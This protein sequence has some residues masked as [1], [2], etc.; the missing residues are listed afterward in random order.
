MITVRQLGYLAGS[1]GQRNVRLHGGGSDDASEGA[2]DLPS[3]PNCAYL[4]CKHLAVFGV[5][6]PATGNAWVPLACSQHAPRSWMTRQPCSSRVCEISKCGT[7]VKDSAQWC[8]PHRDMIAEIQATYPKEGMEAILYRLRG[9]DQDA[10]LQRSKAFL[11]SSDYLQLRDRVAHKLSALTPEDMSTVPLTAAHTCVDTC[12]TSPHDAHMLALADARLR[13]MGHRAMDDIRSL[14]G[15]LGALGTGDVLM[16][17]TKGTKA[18]MFPHANDQWL[19]EDFNSFAAHANTAKKSYI[20]SYDIGLL[21]KEICVVDVDSHA[22]AKEL[23]ERFPQLTE[24]PCEVTK[25]GMHYF[26]MRSKFAD[27]H[28]YYDGVAQLIPGVD[29]KT[30]ALTGTGGFLVVAPS[31]DKLWVRPPWTTQVQPIPKEILCAIATPKHPCCKLAIHFVNTVDGQETREVVNYDRDACFHEFAYLRPVLDGHIEESES[32][33]DTE[34]GALSVATA[35]VPDCTSL[36]FQELINLYKN[37][38]TQT[39][40]TVE[41]YRRLLQV[42]DFLGAP[43][44]VLRHMRAGGSL[45]MLMEVETVFPGFGHAMH[46][47]MLFNRC[48]ANDL[49]LEAVQEG[50]LPSPVLLARNEAW[51]FRMATRAPTPAVQSDWL[52]RVPQF[53]H[54]WLMRHPKNLVMAGGAALA[55]L[56]GEIQPKA[57][58]DFFLHSATEEEATTILRELADYP[59]VMLARQNALAVTFSVGAAGRGAKDWDGQDQYTAQVVLRLYESP[60][61]VLSGFDLQPVK[62]LIM[63]KQQEDGSLALAPLALPSWFISVANRVMMVEPDMFGAA[64]T[65]RVLKYC[66]RRYNA[67]IPGS[68]SAAQKPFT[69]SEVRANL[70]GVGVLV[71]YSQEREM[72]VRALR[73][74]AGS[75]MDIPSLLW[76][77][78]RNRMVSVAAY[79]A[80]YPS[81][82]DVMSRFRRAK[83]SDYDTYIAMN[84]WRF[85]RYVWA[86]AFKVIAGMTEVPQMDWDALQWQHITTSVRTFKHQSPAWAS[87][88]DM[89][90]WNQALAEDLL[91]GV[92]HELHRR[93]LLTWGSGSQ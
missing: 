76:R 60:M 36:E 91:P 37:G 14:T 19:W 77:S 82:R 52:A 66:T 59:G 81:I 25:K 22:L 61:Q 1:L 32:G 3:K 9:R 51:L 83:R 64:S 56:T 17:C 92:E 67:Y 35:Y 46:Q 39:F 74:S 15:W 16:P 88:Y 12:V 33:S 48:M 26:F 31:T 53:A 6:N 75:L 55:A 57:D 70:K 49:Q 93:C 11:V 72:E 78:M 90:A 7:R 4:D 71:G 65:M 30:R 43:P 34:E 63:A 68:N 10:D 85:A 24:A 28:G 21:L 62:C 13:D 42:I 5:R 45:P 89:S 27:Q 69:S 18:P 29:F 41:F 86:L 8:G 38:V 47:E 58:Y 20:Q 54:D 50:P 79:K 80:D 2:V 40:P 87:F 23:E 44:R 84:A 73:G